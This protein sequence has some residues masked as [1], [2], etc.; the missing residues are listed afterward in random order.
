M[1]LMT[2]GDSPP[3]GRSASDLSLIIES[4]VSPPVAYDDR[5]TIPAKDP[6]VGFHPD[7]TA[8]ANDVT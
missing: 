4:D 3:S 6:R 2:H 5:R 8:E 1:T 7:A